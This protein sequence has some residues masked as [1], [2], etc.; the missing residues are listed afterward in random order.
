MSNSPSTV[1]LITGANS[2]VGFATAKAVA[3]AS[4]EYHVIIGSRSLANGQAAVQEIQSSET[5]KGSLSSVQIDVTD[6][7]SIESA[8]K[9]IESQFGRLDVLINNAGVASQAQSTKTAMEETFAVNSIGPALVAETFNPL[10]MKSARPYSIFVSSV[11]GSLSEAADPASLAYY[12][13]GVTYRMSKAALNMLVVQQHKQFG[14][15]GIH[16]FAVCPG[17]VRSNLR[18]KDEEAVSAGGRAGDPMVSAEMILGIIEKKRD[19]DVG[20]FLRGER[21]VNW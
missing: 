10:L 15:K 16:V 8:A 13:D 19:G 7:T 1:V 4:P 3:L 9:Q 17:L 20:K 12:Y 14:P 21:V 18:G 2:G 6:P 11:L 5:T